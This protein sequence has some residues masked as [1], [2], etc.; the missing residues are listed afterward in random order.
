M[1]TLE[2]TCTVHRKSPAA[3]QRLDQ[4]SLKL[5]IEFQRAV[6]HTPFIPFSIL[7]TQAVQLRDRAD[8]A[9]IERFSASLTPESDV[10]VSPTHPHRI[11]ELL[12]RTARLFI[13]SSAE[14]L[15]T[16]S[17]L[18]LPLAV[19]LNDLEFPH[20]GT[21]TEPAANDVLNMEGLQT[22]SLTDWYYSNQQIMDLMYQ[23]GMPWNS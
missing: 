15:P 22:Y 3:G 16:D 9:R 12:S 1:S 14:S 13:E 5:I 6:L 4:Q 11:Y 10:L 7:F 23:D 19:T 18:T 8:L 2:E 20:L 21:E 17:T